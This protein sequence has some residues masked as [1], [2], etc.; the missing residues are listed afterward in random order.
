[1]QLCFECIFFTLFSYI[2][3]QPIGGGFDCGC[4]TGS[5][6][7]EHFTLNVSY[8]RHRFRRRACRNKSCTS[9]RRR[10]FPILQTFEFHR[11]SLAEPFLRRRVW[12]YVG[13]CLGDI[14][15]GRRYCGNTR[16]Y[17]SFGEARSF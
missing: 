4:K 2:R 11:T 12:R 3:V 13:R 15:T 10:M 5:G 1:M 16:V 14:G 17:W 7:F 6:T 8:Q 9:H